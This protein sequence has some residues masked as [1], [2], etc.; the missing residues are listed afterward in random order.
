LQI[1]VQ[2][3]NDFTAGRIDASLHGGGLTEVA[4]VPEYLYMGAVT[5]RF[6]VQ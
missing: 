1:P 6:L 3:G 4:A 2:S 5:D